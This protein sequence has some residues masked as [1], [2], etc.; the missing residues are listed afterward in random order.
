MSDET[1]ALRVQHND[2]ILTQ[3]TEVNDKLQQVPAI[4]EDVWPQLQ[5]L[6]RYYTTQWQ[7]D[8]EALEN[9]PRGMYGV[10]SEDGVFNEIGRFYDTM[11]ILRETV[12][13]IVDEYEEGP[14]DD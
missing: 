14:T 6:L 3:V 1:R 13:K 9:D 2:R 10:L 7:G 4:L 8:F 12:A 11:I 5:D